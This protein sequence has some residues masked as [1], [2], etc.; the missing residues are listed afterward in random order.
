MNTKKFLDQ[1]LDEAKNYSQE[2][3]MAF[4]KYI[5]PLTNT[6]KEMEQK[7]KEYNITNEDI[8]KYYD[9]LLVYGLKLGIITYHYQIRKAIEKVN[10]EIYS[11]SEV[12]SLIKEIVIDLLSDITK[13]NARVDGTYDKKLNY[14]YI[15]NQIALDN[16]KDID[17]IDKQKIMDILSKA[18]IVDIMN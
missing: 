10:K 9:D 17:T 16:L 1:A 2:E 4:N 6:M 5:V 7:M 14:K 11:K 15:V 18:K 8:K 13:L 12:K 3:M